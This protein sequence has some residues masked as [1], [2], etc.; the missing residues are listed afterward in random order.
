MDENGSDGKRKDRSPNSPRAGKTVAVVSL[1][2]AAIGLARTFF[3]AGASVAPG[4][5]GA[6]IGVLAYALGSRNLGLTATLL[7]VAV[8]FFGLMASQGIIPGLEATDHAYP[9]DI[10][11][12]GTPC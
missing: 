1:L 4:A 8:M 10:C 12:P 2:F 9:E 7:C 6:A 3:G 5:V 11:E